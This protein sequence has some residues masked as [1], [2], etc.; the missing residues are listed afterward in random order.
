MKYLVCRLFH[1]QRQFIT[2]NFHFYRCNNSN[3]YDSDFSHRSEFQFHSIWRTAENNGWLSMLKHHFLAIFRMVDLLFVQFILVQP[4]FELWTK[5]G[6]TKTGWTKTGCTL[7]DM[8]IS[9]FVR[10]IN[11]IVFFYVVSVLC[12]Y[13]KIY[14]I[15]IC[16]IL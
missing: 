11:V 14:I 9:I 2:A 15:H 10:T 4:V 12:G 7:S 6:W 8:N 5:T 13:I 3:F 16:M 1:K